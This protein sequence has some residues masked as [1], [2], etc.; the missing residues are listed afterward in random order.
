MTEMLLEETDY[1]AWLQKGAKN[2]EDIERW[3]TGISELL[4]R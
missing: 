3:E 1:L 2:P 4:K